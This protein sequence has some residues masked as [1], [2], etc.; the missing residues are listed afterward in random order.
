MILL[1]VVLG[2]PAAVA[3][4][5]PSPPRPCD[6]APTGIATSDYWLHFTV[7]PGLMPDPQFD[8]LPA[9]LAVH[10]VRPVYADG[11]CP[12]VVTKAAVLIHGK[13]VPG[14]PTFDLRDPATGGGDLSVQDALAQAGIDTFDPSL[15]GYGRS[16]RFDNGLDDPANASLRG[17]LADGSCP[18]PEG[19]DRTAVP[20]ALDQQGTVLAVNPLAGQRL[21]HSSN[22]RFAR[23]DVWVR[24]IRQVIDDALARAKPTDGK[25]VLVGYSAGGQR[26]GRTLYAANPVLPGSAAVIAKVSRVV[27]VSSLFGGP[28]EETAP[29]SGFPSFPLVVSD[30]SSSN[31]A[32]T[33][34]A[35]IEANCPGHIVP[36][37]QQQLWTQ[38]MQGD[39]IGSQWGGTDPGEPTGL[40]RSPTFSGY[41][42]NATVAGQLSTPTLVIQGLGDT[43][44]PTGPGTGAAIYNALPASMTNKVLVEIQCASHALPIE[45]CSGAR[46]TP[47]SGSPYGEPPGT[48][49]GGPHS[50]LDAA[51]I[52]WITRGTFDGA[53][54][55]RFNVDPSGVVSSG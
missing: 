44:I 35:A 31:A 2:L 43:V 10:R 45:G 47:A 19:C 38:M 29:L 14:P 52:E 48:P 16:T 6:K 42:W 23:V 37:S 30:E 3:A 15:L 22:F 32:W 46:C 5:Q 1:A 27:F 36:G 55:G 4:K 49:W 50:T 39:P 28:T 41:G 9:K 21:P 17:Y 53:A 7:P 18:Y 40:D 11:K 24:D 34:P 12:D 33:M 13:S 8:G 26:V 54:D 25:V 51:L 20:F